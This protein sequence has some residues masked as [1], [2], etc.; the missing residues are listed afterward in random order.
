MSRMELYERLGVSKDADVNEIKKAYKKLAMT[1]HPDRGGDPE[2]FKKIQQAHE[3]LTDDSKRRMYDM[4]GSADGEMPQG[5]PFPGG[6][7]FGGMP[8]DMGDLFGGLFGMGGMGGMGGMQ[9]P[10]MRVKRPQGPPKTIEIPLTLKDFYHGKTIQVKFE[11]NKFCEVC[12][13]EGATSFQ[14]CGTCKGH[15]VVRQ[16]MMMGPIQAINEGPCRDCMG[17]G[18]KPSGNCYVCSG[19]KTKV[20]EKTIDVKI[21][22]GMKPGEVLVFP[23]E[24]SDDPSYEEPGDV[25]FLLQDAAGDDGWTRKGDDLE[26]HCAMTLVE[27]LLGCSKT[28]QGH[29][30]YPDGLEIQIPLGAQNGEVLVVQEKGMKRKGAGF[31]AL[32]CKLHISVTD[33]DREVLKRNEPM[34]K[35]M[36]I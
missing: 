6:M 16:V 35:A 19:K 15:G 33:K 13:G 17:Q 1:H 3:V 30:G 2:E 23:K 32:H 14:S 31:G 8:F 12:K 9:R 7:P 36:F 10:G 28:L 29:P 20:Q 25:H 21:E 26:T 24:C 18:K 27:S 5:T 11:R 34:L 4:T 22:A